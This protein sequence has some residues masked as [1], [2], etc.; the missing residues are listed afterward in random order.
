MR[1]RFSKRQAFWSLVLFALWL[2]LSESFHPAHM[3]V[4]LAAAA[5][6]AALHSASRPSRP[7]SVRWLRAL[8]YFP[9]LFREILAGGIRLCYLILHPRMPIRPKLFRCPTSLENDL[10]ITLLGNSITLTPGTV[11]VEASPDE[12]VVHAI[13]GDSTGEAEIRRL[14][15]RVAAVFSSRGEQK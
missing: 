14:E 9:W 8:A 15:T 11:T 3:L 13:D 4:G 1:M 12:L 7:Y 10:A 2:L 6:V 5:G